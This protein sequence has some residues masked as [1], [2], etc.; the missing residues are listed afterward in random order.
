M[1]IIIQYSGWTGVKRC[2]IYWLGNNH[3]E[4]F[5]MSRAFAEVCEGE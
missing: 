2:T 5:A 1:S 4:I 3:K